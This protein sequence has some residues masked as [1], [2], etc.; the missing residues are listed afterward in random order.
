MVADRDTSD[1]HN[2][3]ND[4]HDR[5][6]GGVGG[7]GGR[8][9][10]DNAKGGG[11]RVKGTGNDMSDSG[12][13][14]DMSD[15][16]TG[17]D[18]SDGGG[19]DG[20]AGFRDAR[21]GCSRVSADITIVQHLSAEGTDAF[22]QI[23]GGAVIPPSVLEEYFCNARITGVVFSSE[24][25]PLWHGHAKRRATKAQMNALRARYGACGGCG[26]NMWRGSTRLA[27]AMSGSVRLAEVA[28][29]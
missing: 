7:G 8:S 9:G 2:A 13:G 17:N 5:A 27:V 10:N 29:A 11:G 3:N 19:G 4:N 15:S 23:D 25:M 6:A 21:C 24:G 28:D 18:V 14:N 20:E 1:A 22:A 12:T 26:A 16:S